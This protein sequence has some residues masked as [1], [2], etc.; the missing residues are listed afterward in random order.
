MGSVNC[1]NA[2][3]V[4]LRVLQVGRCVTVMKGW[5]TNVDYGDFGGHDYDYAS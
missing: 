4:A 5:R 2:V 3:S 1:S